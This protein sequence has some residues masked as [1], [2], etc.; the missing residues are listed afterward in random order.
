MIYYLKKA[1]AP[2]T[3]R[4]DTFYDKNKAVEMA[5]KES[6]RTGDEFSVVK[7]EVVYK[8]NTQGKTK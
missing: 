3:N 4:G 5:K 6:I 8:T 2:I 7:V 1:D